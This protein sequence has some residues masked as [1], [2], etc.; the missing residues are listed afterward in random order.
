MWPSLKTLQNILTISKAARVDVERYWSCLFAKAL[1][2]C[3]VKVVVTN[4]GSG[5]GTS[6]AVWAGTLAAAPAAE[7]KK[8][9]KKGE[10]VEESDAA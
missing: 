3:S 1:E 7:E 10:T 9:E 2:R 5:V 8:K 6:S 4:W